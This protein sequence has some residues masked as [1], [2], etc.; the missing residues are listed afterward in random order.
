MKTQTPLRQTFD[1]FELK[2]CQSSKGWFLA[3]ALQ[4]LLTAGLL[5]L[6]KLS[7]GCLWER[8]VHIL[9]LI[10]IVAT[11]GLAL[12]TIRA[13]LVEL[14]M[15]WR[16]YSQGLIK[17]ASESGLHRIS[18]KLTN[19]QERYIQSAIWKLRLIAAGLTI[20]FFIMPLVLSIVAVAL[21]LGYAPANPHD[22]WTMIALFTSFG[23]FIVAGYFRW[24]IVP[25][26][27]PVRVHAQAR[28]AYP[29]RVRNKNV[30]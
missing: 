16:N 25:T 2:L 28:R 30:Q 22:P 3:T 15:H 18:V 8:H 5:A 10:G 24:T 19:A 21:S 7:A 14:F 12:R 20:P 27:A 17:R 4:A 29:Q 23:A 11:W 13:R 6:A 1:P 9:M 26:P